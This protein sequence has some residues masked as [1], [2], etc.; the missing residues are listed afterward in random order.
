M[1]TTS[2]IAAGLEREVSRSFLAAD[3]LDEFS[4]AIIRILSDTALS[5]RLTVN[6]Y[7]FSKKWNEENLNNPAGILN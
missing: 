6:A 1:I 5:N 4:K 3:H 7:N 2:I